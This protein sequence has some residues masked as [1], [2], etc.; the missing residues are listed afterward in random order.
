M[1]A[2]STLVAYVARRE[3]DS[4][5]PKSSLTMLVG[6]GGESTP[7]EMAPG[8]LVVVRESGT[9]ELAPGTL[10][11]V[12]GSGTPELGLGA[13]SCPNADLH[14][15]LVL[16]LVEVGLNDP[17]HT[18]K[19]ENAT[20]MARRIVESL[21]AFYREMNTGKR[22]VEAL[23]LGW[24]T[25]GQTR[26]GQQKTETMVTFFLHAWQRRGNKGGD[27]PS[28]EEEWAQAQKRGS[29]TW[30]KAATAHLKKDVTV[31]GGCW[32]GAVVRSVRMQGDALPTRRELSDWESGA[33]T[34]HW[35]PPG[36]EEAAKASFVR[37]EGFRSQREL[38]EVGRNLYWPGVGREPTG[39]LA[40]PT[41]G[42]APLDGGP[43]LGPPRPPPH[44]GTGMERAPGRGASMKRTRPSGA[45]GDAGPL[46]QT[47]M[48]VADGK[49]PEGEESEGEEPDLALGGADEAPGNLE[50]RRQL[51]V[52][53]A[54]LRRRA[55]E[56]AERA[57]EDAELQKQLL[58][59]QHA[60]RA[61]PTSLHAHWH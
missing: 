55:A 60:R 38:I 56:D 44:H 59:L 50:L 6:A 57:A 32:R 33:C 21:S 37:F 25:R 22:V 3:V 45:D 9:P 47:A 39:C 1:K 23:M 29:E 52:A 42:R 11:V 12:G 51:D 16:T 24:V 31:L 35:D 30:R 46:A 53:H 5:L 14:A 28:E 27:A 61:R 7:P 4:I 17:G 40:S 8:T 41:I 15:D 20:E 48:R 43:L 34:V 19:E 58:K 36:W 10:V 2:A 54:A 49:E 26:Y 18:V 13:A